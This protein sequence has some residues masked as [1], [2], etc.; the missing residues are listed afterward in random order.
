MRDEI[1][2]ARAP[3]QQNLAEALDC[4]EEMLGRPEPVA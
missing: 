3:P 1:N 4:D 2:P